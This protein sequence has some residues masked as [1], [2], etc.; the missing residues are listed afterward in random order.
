MAV[1]VIGYCEDD[2]VFKYGP[3]VI[4]RVTGM[5]HCR[6]EVEVKNSKCPALL[7]A[8]IYAMLRAETTCPVGCTRKD[9]IEPWVEWLNNR[10]RDGQI[11]LAGDIWVAPKY[12]GTGD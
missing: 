11:V 4:C 6:I 12:L 7:D 3:F 2:V 9:Y 5:D 1:Q 8:S 10:V